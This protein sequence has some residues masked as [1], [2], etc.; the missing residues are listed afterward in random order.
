[1]A[2]ALLT[3]ARYKVEVHT[4]VQR[5]QKRLQSFAYQLSRVVHVTRLGGG[6]AET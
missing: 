6:G 4:Q 1:M 5:E 3:S 2:S